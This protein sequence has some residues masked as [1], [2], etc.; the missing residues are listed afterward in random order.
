MVGD[1]HL[2][3]QPSRRGKSKNGFIVHQDGRSGAFC[4][5]DNIN[6]SN[7]ARH[8]GKYMVLELSDGFRTYMWHLV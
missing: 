6:S 1:A 3:T 2:R 5:I 7:P 8:G 4:A